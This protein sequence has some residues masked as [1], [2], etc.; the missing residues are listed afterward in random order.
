MKTR[1]RSARHR[2]F[3][4]LEAMLAVA[5][6][7]LGM[8]ALGRCVSAG[9][10]AEQFKAEDARARRVLENRLAE[11]EAGA[12]P[13]DKTLTETLKEPFAGF[14][15]TQTPTE[16][17]MQNEKKEDLA[18]LYAVNIEVSWSSGRDK[19]SKSLIV[20]VQKRDR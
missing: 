17:K 13:I 3:V 16:L 19:S 5:I 12:V 2:G 9:L 1:A 18:G 8:L 6:F 7:A 15:L 20:Y 4:L 11:I 10:A 14:K